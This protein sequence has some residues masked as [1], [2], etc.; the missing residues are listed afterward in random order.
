MYLFSQLFLNFFQKWKRLPNKSNQLRQVINVQHLKL[1]PLCFCFIIK[2]NFDHNPC[3]FAGWDIK[4]LSFCFW[5][6]MS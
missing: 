1:K 5:C 3:T 4:V 2:A 6:N